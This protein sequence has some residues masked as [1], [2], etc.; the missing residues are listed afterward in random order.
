MTSTEIPFNLFSCNCHPQLTIKSLEKVGGGWRS[1]RERERR[2]E[3]I[4]HRVSRET[5][6]QNKNKNTTQGVRF[7]KADIIQDIILFASYFERSF[8]NFQISV[9]LRAIKCTVFKILILEK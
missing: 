5:P 2:G 9:N 1:G 6:Q 4:K 8:Q 3:L 7:Y